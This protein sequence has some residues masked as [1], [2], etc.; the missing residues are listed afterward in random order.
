MLSKP[1]RSFLA[2]QNQESVH[3]SAD[4]MLGDLEQSI[5]ELKRFLGIEV[6]H[7]GT[8]SYRKEREVKKLFTTED[9]ITTSLRKPS[10]SKVQK[11]LS[12]STQRNLWERPYMSS[13]YRI[14]YLVWYTVAHFCD[15][16]FSLYSLTFQ[17]GLSPGTALN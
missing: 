13:E 15:M 7:D 3:L 16:I 14:F 6:R 2:H 5:C 1:C 11:G 8:D 9:D 4:Q 17:E 12:Q 10:S